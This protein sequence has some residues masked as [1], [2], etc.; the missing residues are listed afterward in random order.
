MKLAS[1]TLKHFFFKKRKPME[2]VAA[3]RRQRRHQDDWDGYHGGI[4]CDRSSS[5]KAG[6]VL[7]DGQ[8]ED[9]AP[10]DHGGRMGRGY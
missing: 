6:K 7:E 8:A 4:R 3:K 5:R 10:L 1:G 2:A 9:N